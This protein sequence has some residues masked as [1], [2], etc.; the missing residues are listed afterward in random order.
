MKKTALILGAVFL[1][2]SLS[3]PVW[4]KESVKLEILAFPE[5]PP[6]AV[7]I[8]SVEMHATPYPLPDFRP[9]V[10]RIKVSRKGIGLERRVLLKA[11]THVILVADFIK[12]EI[13]VKNQDSLS[14][15]PLQGET[16]IIIK[17]SRNKRPA[18]QRPSPGTKDET[19]VDKNRPPETE[20]TDKPE[21]HKKRGQAS[22]PPVKPGQAEPKT[23]PPAP[24]ISKNEDYFGPP[25]PSK[26]REAPSNETK[27]PSAG[28]TPAEPAEESAETGEENSGRQE[29][30][31]PEETKPPEKEQPGS[32]S[33]AHPCPPEGDIQCNRWKADTIRGVVYKYY[34]MLINNDFDEA[35]NYW[36]TGKTRGWFYGAAQKFC[37]IHGFAIRGFE[38]GRDSETKARTMY[39][40]DLKDRDGTIIETWKMET[41]LVKK[42]SIWMITSTEGKMVEE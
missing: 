5:K 17:P 24:Q 1:L 9:G 41:S 33:Y 25:V 31:D 27:E 13:E 40:V 26:Y 38:A 23:A 11:S 29:E 4:P 3:G 20:K 14:Y 32:E 35:Y 39:I 22:G 19:G 21:V 12:H 28:E 8:D 2:M 7:W 6:A 34:C 10:H 18:K 16:R 15:D 37:S 30:P 36:S 42:G